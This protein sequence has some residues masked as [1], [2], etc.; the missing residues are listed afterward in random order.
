MWY[1]GGGGVR[2]LDLC[3]VLVLPHLILYS[4][5]V[6]AAGE[7]MTNPLDLLRT[8][9]LHLQTQFH[10]GSCWCCRFPWQ[11]GPSPAR[12][13][14]RSPHN[15]CDRCTS[16]PVRGS[17]AAGPLTRNSASIKHPVERGVYAVVCPGEIGSHWLEIYYKSPCQF[18]N[19]SAAKC[20][21]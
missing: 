1:F 18:V 11:A 13:L 2:P 8:W 7:F 19:W 9:C 14:G 15:H 6:P 17:P 16:I 10:F 21:F 4:T 3:V 20:K 5:S 12:V